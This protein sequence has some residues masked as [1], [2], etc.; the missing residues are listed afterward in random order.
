LRDFELWSK[1]LFVIR[2]KADSSI[3]GAHGNVERFYLLIK[4]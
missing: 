4:L 2:D 3:S 1:K